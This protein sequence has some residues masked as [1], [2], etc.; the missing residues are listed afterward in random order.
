MAV[1]RAV[2]L[3]DPGL[4][5]G[6]GFGAVGGCELPPRGR[7]FGVVAVRVGVGGFGELFQGVLVLA[8]SVADAG[9]E[10]GELVSAENFILVTRPDDIR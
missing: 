2:D 3:L 1:A 6:E 5:A 4:E 7:G 10:V 8:E 9:D